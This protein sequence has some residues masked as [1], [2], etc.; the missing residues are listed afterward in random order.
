MILGYSDDD[1]NAAVSDCL[2]KSINTTLNAPE[3]V[4]LAELLLELNPSMD[5]VKFAKGEARQ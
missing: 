4:E 1:V 2:T 3:E 5:M